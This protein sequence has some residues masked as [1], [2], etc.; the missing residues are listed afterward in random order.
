[1]RGL[2]Q[3]FMNHF[4]YKIMESLLRLKVQQWRRTL[5]SM[6]HHLQI[7]AAAQV[8]P[9]L[10][11]QDDGVA[12]LAE[13]LRHCPVRLFDQSDHSQHRRWI[14]GQSVGLVIKAHVAADDWNLEMLARILEALNGENELPH[15]LG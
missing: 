12:V 15:D 1:M 11:E 14:D 13:P 3:S 4:Q 10:S 2:N 9:R 7:F 8:I 5:F 6:L